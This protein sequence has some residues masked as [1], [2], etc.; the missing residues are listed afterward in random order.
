[1][2]RPEG[3]EAENWPCVVCLHGNSSSRLE[4]AKT[5]VIQAA[6]LARCALVA[7]DFAG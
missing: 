2:W 5:N 6:M 4:A 3:L 7:F 1:V